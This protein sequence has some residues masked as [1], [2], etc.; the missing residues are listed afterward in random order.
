M[1]S[2]VRVANLY[3]I[4][5]AIT[6]HEAVLFCLKY[7]KNNCNLTALI[8]TIIKVDIYNKYLTRNIRLILV[9]YTTQIVWILFIDYT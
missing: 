8:K 6:D 5:I 1:N 4:L 9:R 7:T 3:R 2:L